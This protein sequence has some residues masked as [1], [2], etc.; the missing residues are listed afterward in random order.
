M[1]YN[2][3]CTID[4]NFDTKN[5][6]ESDIREIIAR[7][8]DFIKWCE[9]NTIAPYYVNNYYSPIGIRVKFIYEQDHQ[10]FINFIAQYQTLFLHK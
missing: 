9:N 4:Y 1:I 10:H 8:Y 5:V 6:S 3:N 7:H 2:H